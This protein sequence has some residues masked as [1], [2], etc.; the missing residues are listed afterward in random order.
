MKI[1]HTAC[2]AGALCAYLGTSALAQSISIERRDFEPPMVNITVESIYDFEKTF[3]LKIRR[4]VSLMPLDKQIDLV[5][6]I[7]FRDARGIKITSGWDID[8]T[9]D[10]I[11][12][13]SGGSA[14]IVKIIDS[15]LGVQIV[16]S[17]KDNQ[18]RFIAPPPDQIAAFNSFGDRLCYR[19]EDLDVAMP[20][21]S[22]AL[23]LDRS[24]SM[25]PVINDVKQVA[26][27]FLNILPDHAS[28]YVTS[29]SG[30][31]TSHR[32]KQ[33][34]TC[35]AENFDLSTIAAGG[36]T[37][38]FT[39]LQGLYELLNNSAQQSQQKAVI[40]ITDGRVSN[41]AVEAAKRKEELAKNKKGIPTFVYWL[42]NHDEQ[43]LRGLADSFI[44]HQGSVKASLAKYFSIIGE[45]I[46][47]ERVLTLQSCK[48]AQHGSP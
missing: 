48:G 19:Y 45:G 35:R 28:C 7:D 33:D 38:L 8:P 3:S 41:S 39:P 37:D 40:I 42:G 34:A 43:H 25:A 14:E 29:F 44:T 47:K 24:G 11:V 13:F 31:A 1:L 16:A 5:N 46:K 21:M 23:L 18:G 26:A 15:P 17:F 22:I 4:D 6:S 10:V 12:G 36:V 32:K 9:R 27:D 30:A 20:P 2:L